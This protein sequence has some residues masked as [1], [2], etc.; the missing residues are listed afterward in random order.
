MIGHLRFNKFLFIFSYIVTFAIDS[1]T[2]GEQLCKF[3]WRQSVL[4]KPHFA[5]LTYEM[6]VL[7]INNGLFTFNIQ[8]PR[9]HEIKFLHILYIALLLVVL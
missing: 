2:L 1:S 8:V 3:N 5:V 9:I 7:T 4:K 6:P